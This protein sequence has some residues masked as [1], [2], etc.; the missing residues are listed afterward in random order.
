VEKHGQATLRLF[1]Q[2][3][4][5]GA[6]LDGIQRRDEIAQERRSGIPLIEN[7]VFRRHPPSPLSASRTLLTQPG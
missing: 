4:D 2:L 1:D 3:A 7:D 5:L 6:L